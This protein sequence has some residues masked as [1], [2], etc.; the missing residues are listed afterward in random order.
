MPTRFCLIFPP[1]SAKIIVIEGVNECEKEYHARL[2][3]LFLFAKALTNCVIQAD[4]TISPITSTI[5]LS[6]Q[7]G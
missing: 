4:Q 3:E 1:E 6:I 7:A 5:Q 2:L